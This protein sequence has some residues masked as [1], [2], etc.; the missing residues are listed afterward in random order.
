MTIATAL[1]YLLAAVLF[2]LGLLFLST[3]YHKSF[4]SFCSSFS[5]V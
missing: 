1:V 5:A 4:P 2:I 3:G